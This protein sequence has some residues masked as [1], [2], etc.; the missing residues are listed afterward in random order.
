MYMSNTTNH[1]RNTYYDSLL[2]LLPRPVQVSLLSSPPLPKNTFKVSPL[3]PFPI[4]P[5]S[6]PY[7]LPLHILKSFLTLHHPGGSLSK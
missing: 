7:K 1:I 4:L 2:E 5:S 6:L 3:F